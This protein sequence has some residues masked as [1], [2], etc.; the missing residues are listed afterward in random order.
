MSGI[1][2]KLRQVVS[3]ETYE[4][5]QAAEA[6]E[7]AENVRAERLRCA[8]SNDAWTEIP[9]P[10][11]VRRGR[12]FLVDAERDFVHTPYR[13]E[14]WSP[15]KATLEYVDPRTPMAYSVTDGQVRFLETQTLPR[16]WSDVVARQTQRQHAAAKR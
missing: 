3:L 11:L 8:R 6:R 12:G 5:R 10:R 15:G 1:G 16:T 13:G 9:E 4:D 2:T 7:H 14:L